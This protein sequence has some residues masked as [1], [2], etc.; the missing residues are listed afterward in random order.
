MTVITLWAICPEG[1]I[2]PMR[3]VFWEDNKVKM[4]DQRLLPHELVIAEY[5]RVEGV[6]YSIA[7]MVVRGAPAI[8]ATGAYGMA[9]A[10]LNSPATKRDELLADLIAAKKMLD[11][12]RPTAVNLSWATARLLDLAEHTVLPNVDDL[13]SALLAEAEAVADEDVEINRRMGFHGAA[14]IPDGANLPAPLQH[15]RPGGGRFWHGAG[16]RLRLPGTGQ[17]HSRVGGRNAAAAA[18]RTSHG[19][20]ADARRHAHALDRRQR[21][22]PPHACRQGGRRDLRRRP[23]GG[24]RRRGQQGRLVQAG[25]GGQR[26]RHPRLCGRAHQHD[27]S[28]CCPTATRFPS[29]SATRA[30]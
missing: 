24:Q 3:T 5:D 25:R 14:L 4:I 27:R 8:G 10:A 17:A 6:A 28:Q 19:V 16:R 21:R 11:A 7:D 15:R 29:R 23:G 12:S 13:R 30:R 9:L 20:G 22:R 18:G 2:L 1:F 26:E